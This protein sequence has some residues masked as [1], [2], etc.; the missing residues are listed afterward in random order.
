MPKFPAGDRETSGPLP[1]HPRVNDT[2]AKLGALAPWIVAAA[3]ASP[4]CESKLDSIDHPSGTV[5][6]GGQHGEDTEHPPDTDHPPLPD[7]PATYANC[8]LA[9][10]SPDEASCP[11]GAGFAMD[12][13]K[14][15]CVA[16][17]CIEPCVTDDDCAAPA[18]VT[19]QGECGESQT[20]RLRCDAGRTCPEGMTCDD[21]VLEN[22]H[23][24]GVHYCLWATADEFVCA[25]VLSPAMMNPC[26]DVTNASSC[27]AKVSDVGSDRC[28]WIEENIIASGSSTCDAAGVQGRC[29]WVQETDDCEG[30]EAC[31]AADARVHW[32]DLG[33]GTVGLSTFACDLRPSRWEEYESCDFTGAATIPLVCDCGCE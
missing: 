17:A 12:G 9:F 21:A 14:D 11:A 2:N 19:A 1:G 22:P 31:P 6:S 24:N 8:L 7:G 15:S 27:N 30:I 10:V 13:L 16:C 4:A 23:P 28:I 33:G 3:I 5:T 18:G 26:A 29:V 25:E 32:R 20:C